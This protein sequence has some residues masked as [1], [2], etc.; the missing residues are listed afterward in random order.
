M[1]EI[2]PSRRSFLRGFGALLAAPAIVQVANLMPIRAPQL[3][4]KTEIINQVLINSGIS[5]SRSN[6]LLTLDMITREA[7]QLFT[8]NNAFLQSMNKQWNSE[9]EFVQPRLGNTVRI[10]LPRDFKVTNTEL[11]LS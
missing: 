9:F 10:R 1:S 2:I 3:V 8:Q 7:V 5:V 11:H 6:S 4:T